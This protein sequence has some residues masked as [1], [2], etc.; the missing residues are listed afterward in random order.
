MN[1]RERR[2]AGQESN[3]ASSVSR[4]AA[5]PGE[6]GHPHLEAVAEL[7]RAH[8]LDPA[9]AEICNSMGI[10][11]RR[12]G[13]PEEA[14]IWFD[15]ALS[16]RPDFL[17]TANKK[18]S[19]LVDLGRYDQ[20]LA[21]SL[22][23][24]AADP[25]NA[26]AEFNVGFLQLLRG[27]LAAGWARREARWRLPNPPITYNFSQPMWLGDQPIAGR[28]ILIHQDEGLGDT[29]QFVRY[30]PM[31]AARGAR[32]ILLVADALVPL[33]SKL[34][35]VS[36]C[37]PKSADVYVSFD[38]YCPITT[39]PL[40]FGTTLAAIPAATPYLSADEQRARV[41]EQRLGP[42]DKMRVGLVWS[43]NPTQSN[44]HNRSTN[45]RTL[46]PL[47]GLDATFVSLQ[48][49]A[50]PDDRALLAQTDIVDLTVHLTDFAETAALL[51]CLDLVISVDTG[52]AHLAGAL[53]RP[54][55]IMLCYAPDYRWLL[56]RDDSPWYPTARLFRQRK[57]R[58]YDDVVARVRSELAVRIP[59]WSAARSEQPD[60]PRSDIA[61]LMCQAGLALMRA[62]NHADAERCC[63]EALAQN[64][65]HADALHLM[66]LLSLQH[67]Q[68]DEAVKWLSHAIRSDPKPLYLRSLGTTLLKQGRGEEA[69]QVIDKA[70]QLKADDADLW[71]N[72]GDALVEMDRPQ[73][74]ILSYQ[75]ALKLNPRHLEAARKAAIMLQQAGRDEEALS[76]FNLSEGLEPDHLPTLHRRALALSNLQRFEE[77]LAD[78]IRAY[79]LDPGAG[80]CEN[81]GNVLRALSRHDEAIAWYDRALALRP[82]SA[83]T[84]DN[85]A[86]ALVQLHRFDE[87]IAASRLAIAADPGYAVAKW[88]LALVHLVTGSF[89]AGWAGRE[90]RWQIPSFSRSYPRLSAP[91]W[92]GAESVAG[93]TILVCAEEGFGDSIQF[94]RYV[95][96]L[97]A[98][99]ARVILVVQDALCSLLAGMEGVGQCLP[100][101]APAL[102][103]C[104]YHCP[105]S[106]LPLA[107]GTGLETIPAATSYLRAPAER[108]RVWE[109]RLGAHDRLRVGLVWSGN[110][111]HNND[112]N[113]SLSLRLL[114]PILDLEA[115]FV[116]LQKEPRPDDRAVLDERKTI[117]D[118]TADLTDF[119]ETAALISCLDL[120]ITVD[121]S[122]AH[123]AGAL[124]RPTWILLPHM[125]DWR[126]LLGR[127]DSPWYPTMRLFRQA[128]PGDYSSV[129]E[130]VRIELRARIA[131]KEHYE[132]GLRHM[133]AG[134]HLDAQL[135]CQQALANESGHAD[136]LH[137]MGLLSLQLQ[138]H[139]EAI[140]WISLALRQDL[141]PV[142][143]LSL[144][145]ILRLQ[146][147]HDEVL[148]V[149]DK[150]VQLG[151]DAAALWMLR[152]RTLVDLKRPADAL[153]SF[154]Q[155]LGAD[156][157][158]WD[159]ANQCG[160]VL[161]E[162]GRIEEALSYLGLCD[163]L[164]PN[165]VPT[166]QMRAGLLHGLKRFEE[167]QTLCRQAHALEP[168]N[169]DIC[170][171]L[172]IVLRSL[173]RDEEALQWFDR[174][175]A[176]RPDFK[177]ALHNKA[178]ALT[179][180]R[181]FGEVSAIY[182]SL[183]S[184]DPDDALAHLGIAQLQLLTGNFEAGWAGREA[185]WK[186]AN[187]YP[188]FRQA[189]WLGRESL[190]DRTILM[191]PDEGLGDTIQFVRY[192]PL[193]EKL[194]ARIILVVQ[195][196]LHPLLSNMPGIWQCLPTS[197][198]ALPAFDF[199]C[200][201]MSLPLAFGTRLDTIPSFQSYLPAPPKDRVQVWK[202]R[203]GP[204]DRLRVGLVWSG[205]P[206]HPDDHNRS[207][208][209]AAISDLLKLD[210]DFISLQR[211]P[212]PDDSAV[213]RELTGITD[214]TGHLTDFVET[215]ALIACL[216]LVITVDTSVAHLAAA[217][218]CPTWTLLSYMPD[219][220][221]LLDR[222]DS[223]W[224]P[225]MRLFRQS[226]TREYATVIARVKNA[227][228]ARLAE[229][230]QDRGTD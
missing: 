19:A 225:A 205:N 80:T 147:R 22:N 160:I 64:G 193:L 117:I 198:T 68:Y 150:T 77:A 167:V 73:D 219:Y 178:A 200:P 137:L 206:R 41:W 118:F 104:D 54:T 63:R 81:I 103:D 30:V 126:W 71:R 197:A 16:L 216:D 8:T 204:H 11:L 99:G 154:Q 79:T 14:L 86:V 84:L 187:G 116:S 221:W 48:K 184:T 194:G 26:E 179:R 24:M 156:P 195:D 155:V 39:L 162:M 18:V 140:E 98:Q 158:H 87:A 93:K 66:G 229:W 212:K 134:Q 153:S 37:L 199:H 59:A 108:A 142:Y 50:R 91:M 35:G 146:G 135:R 203:L 175:L 4:T 42:H 90:A 95:P 174:A 51:S 217:Q 188:K 208:P 173:C 163:A 226:E 151:C 49:D 55:W 122:V 109:Q 166:V 114:A 181:R 70:V 129:I 230:R 9:N 96:M 67:Q 168:D 189:M 214:L 78:S 228:S 190:Q 139:D 185:R 107:F 207:I 127:D 1:P 32:V 196:S 65:D 69:L 76:C 192:V 33:L 46:L 47:L 57:P 223:P 125:P 31:L 149:F 183:T 182:E 176:L 82:D 72:L 52:T 201:M 110:P 136:A 120:V 21:I 101:S 130:Q 34:E 27:N 45:L 62:G 13:R 60:P 44:D 92:L 215:A 222:D 148:K 10:L 74:A 177:D 227:L 106:S 128:R 171:N 23:V 180:V 58:D 131:A 28:T 165:H 85:K 112:R 202:E 224:Y 7:G 209:L 159:A 111:K 220:R 43:G 191:A 169:A 133:N 97:A 61:T 124:G 210:A 161:H 119:A 75:Q 138:R 172:G 94:V 145:T 218:G 5:E 12:S 40:A 143:F 17:A 113:R 100:K 3:A 105:M 89:A 123:L 144:A 213:L 25:Q 2:A 56:D 29:V 186:L 132:A 141:K 38:M 88:N 152:G 36:Q 20:A 15:K 53:A 170:N 164:R 6:V 102:P 121:T 211:D 83:V 115:T 157:Q